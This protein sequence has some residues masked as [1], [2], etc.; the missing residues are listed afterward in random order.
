MRV[1]AIAQGMEAQKLKLA[2]KR[3]FPFVVELID[4][5]PHAG[6]DEVEA[7]LND[8]FVMRV[9][10]SKIASECLG[11][12][13]GREHFRRDFCWNG[14]LRE[15]RDCPNTPRETSDEGEHVC[16]ANDFG[17]SQAFG[18]FLTARQNNDGLVRSCRDDR[19]NGQSP[20]NGLSHESFAAAEVDISALPEAPERFA[21]GSGKQKHGLS[22][23]E[24]RVHGPAIG[25]EKTG[26]CHEL[27]E[28][29]PQAME[30]IVR[31][32]VKR[33][34][35]AELIIPVDAE[36]DPID[37]EHAAIVVRDDDRLRRGQSFRPADFAAKIRFDE[38]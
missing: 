13:D 24:H 38:P 30:R 35:E 33:P 20:T 9:F 5:L 11:Q 22:G 28:W 4:G 6:E 17:Y 15:K 31:Q 29:V 36:A 21:S 16:G 27:G 25:A 8:G 26:I 37:R 18:E 23:G 3:V 10:G 32:D 2:N 14:N 19:R 12:M 1:R 34:I 7:G